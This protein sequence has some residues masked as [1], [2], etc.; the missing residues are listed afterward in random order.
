MPLRTR[1]FIII[2][3]VA[4]LILGI[5]VFL[6]IAGKKSSAPVNQPSN[7]GS[8][9]NLPTNNTVPGG[10]QPTIIPNGVPIKPATTAE[11]EKNAAKQ[12]AKIFVE[13]FNTYSSDN[14]YQNIRDVQALVT[15]SFWK[16]L[17][18]RLSLP[19]A[20]VGT[21][22]GATTEVIV[23]NVGVFNTSTASVAIKTRRTTT[24]NNGTT[25]SYQDIIVSLTKSNG[26]WLVDSQTV[27]K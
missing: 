3:I 19:P 10:V 25:V 1:L 27:S 16:T 20:S 7:A 18:A 12:L 24:Q 15:N 4:L 14:A 17:S 22:V 8:D 5:S 2:S 21:F 11:I 6:L 26:A 13:R 23:A 9:G